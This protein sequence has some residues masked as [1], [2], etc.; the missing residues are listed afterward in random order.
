MKYLNIYIALIIFIC[1]SQVKAQDRYATVTVTDTFR[2]NFENSYYFSAVSVKPFSEIITLRGR[3][4]Q[5]PDYSVNYQNGSF[6]L[7]GSVN[8]SIFDTL[9]V[10]YQAYSLGLKKLYQRRSLVLRFDD[11]AS[12]TLMAVKEESARLSPEYFF[13]R[14]IQKSGSIVRGFSVGTTRDF[15]LTSGLRLQLSGKLSDDISITAALT[16]ENTPIQPEGNTEKLE[17]LD[18]VFIEIRH[19]KAV[20]T[21]G[22]YDY[23]QNTGEFGR[24]NRKLQ[25]LKAEAMLERYQG[26]AAIAGSKG[27]FNTNRFNGTEGMQGPYRLTGV[28]N[29][30]EIIVVAGSEKVYLDGEPM[31][32]GEGNDYTIEYASAEVIFTPK[33]LITAASRIYV[34]FEYND[35]RYSRN[36]FAA[37]F[38]TQQLSDRLRIKLGLN[39]E[40]DDETS[41]VDISLSQEDK[42][43]LKNAGDNRLLAAKNGITQA[44]ADSAG[45]Y[46]A[47]YSAT[48][49]LILGTPVRY[50]KYTPGTGEYYVTFSYVGAGRGDYRRESLGVFSFAGPA[51]GDYSPV[52]L[53][54]LPELRQ[55]GNLLIEAEPWK[56]L[57][58]SAE[59]AGS[60]YDKNRLSGLDDQD[61]QGSARTFILELKPKEVSLFGK[62]LGKAG[63]SY[64]DRFISRN[65][66]PPDRINEVE[67]QRNYNITSQDLSSEEFRELGAEL[68]PIRELNLASSFG[69]LR[70]GS[71]FS[72]NRFNSNV[73]FRRGDTSGA[74]YSFDFVKTS[75]GQLKSSW[76]RQSA[77]AFHT[78][79]VFRPAFNFIAEDK[80][81]KTPGSDSLIQGSLRYYEYIPSLAI[82]GLY[83][84]DISMQYSYRED[85]FADGGIMRPES[86]AHTQVYSLNYHGIRNV[87]SNLDVT[88]RKKLFNDHYKKKGELNTETI[89][90]RSQTRMNL[91]DR[92]FD[93]DLFYEAST[94]RSARYER[95]F[96]KVPQ[97]TGNYRYAGDL[98]NNGLA[99]E[100]EFEAVLYDGDFIV[101]S[102]P[103]ERLYP[104]IDLKAG[105]DFSLEFARIFQG[106]GILKK[107]LSVLS[108][109]TTYRMEENSRENDT[110]KIYLLNFAY[111]LSDSN[112]IRGMN[113]FLQDVFLFK[114]NNDFSLRFRFS[115]RNGL[116]NYSSGIENNYFRERGIRLTFRFSEE[117]GNMS[118]YTNGRDYLFT[119][120]S[121]N[122]ARRIDSD[123]ISTDFSYRPVKNVEVGFKL[124]AGRSV[125]AYPLKATVIDE[126][127]QAVR[128]NYSFAQSGRLRMEIERAELGTN[129]TEN[130]IPFELTRGNVVGK[131]YFLRINFE[132]NV[133]GYLQTLLYY[134][135]RF[136]GQGRMLHNARAEARA[137]F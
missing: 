1:I 67:F 61:N 35:R 25:G 41:P 16:D 15:T 51:Q 17:E 42:N 132:Y 105:V 43:I 45:K 54:P 9:F 134:D 116:N 68:I 59:L 81:D 103:T 6:R 133:S 112:T 111:F 102:I 58:I 95:V 36:F 14:D 40:G 88:L 77:G 129:N 66:N 72:S 48:D 80:Q 89:L 49:T 31:T 75:S 64:K 55:S 90:I 114:N 22:D 65:Y 109:Q 38:S 71:L 99:D 56:D 113:S 85:S 52:T 53:L 124:T 136:Q 137:Y 69:Q 83:G 46:H 110:R 100:N 82:A 73:T 115:Q 12:D 20:G 84:L 19:P 27:K 10:T 30:R 120:H 37:G 4:L 96:V 97:G 79:G 60:I 29:E 91:M 93:G 92:F 94:Q 24:I 8:Y 33:R 78:V 87:A 47:T 3:M 107:Y 26:V 23:V 28:N 32:R 131:N 63:F 5:R 74:S 126:N 2:I 7:A 11:S 128:I 127:S 125:D 13:G 62:E 123:R 21:F 121:S 106:E 57:I 98:N 101:S 76:V 70:R 122:R 34:D 108:T 86:R 39:R 104:V 130:Y 50:Y 117:I 18:K 119:S 135:G 44:A 118:E